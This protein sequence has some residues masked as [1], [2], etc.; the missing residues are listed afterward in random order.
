M[1]TQWSKRKSM[2]SSK[3]TH[4]SHNS[5]PGGGIH[6]PKWSAIIEVPLA[7][8]WGWHWQQK[9]ISPK[10]MIRGLKDLQKNRTW[11]GLCRTAVMGRE[12][13]PWPK[14]AA[15]LQLWTVAKKQDCR[16]LLLD[17]PILQEKQKFW[18]FI[19]N[20][21]ILKILGRTNQAYLQVEF[22]LW[23]PA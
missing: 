13:F 16:P 21:L 8:V 6:P 10:A 7:L 20:L 11:N 2:G 14:T 19:R 4:C 18:I 23:G 1:E 5:L 12:G 17:L 9:N 3:Y 22:G 15:P